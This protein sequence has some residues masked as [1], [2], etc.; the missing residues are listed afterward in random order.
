MS[1]NLS[2]WR[3]ARRVD[4]SKRCQSTCPSRMCC[5]RLIET[6]LQTATLSR[7]VGS[8]TSVQRFE[9]W[10]VP[11]LLFSARTLIA[12]FQVSQGWEVV[13]SE[14]RMFLYCT[15][16][17]IV[18]NIF[19]LPALAISTYSLYLLEKASP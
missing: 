2:S 10:I 14:I 5:A 6:K 12:S 15:R 18:S 9:Q 11:V 16:A 3:I 4:S 17:G 19:I 1:L 13:S 7:S 8:V